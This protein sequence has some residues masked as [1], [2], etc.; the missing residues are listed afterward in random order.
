MIGSVAAWREAAA[1]LPDEGIPDRA[2]FGELY[3]WRQVVTHSLTRGHRA[4]VEAARRAIATTL[5]AMCPGGWWWGFSGGK[6]SS[7]LGAIL[8]MD[9]I[10]VPAVSVKDDL[11][12]PGESEF[13]AGLAARWGIR[14]DILRQSGLAGHLAGTSLVDGSLHSPAA[15]LSRTY[16]YRPLAEHRARQ[17]YGG[18]M[19]GLRQEESRGRRLN[20]ATRGLLYLRADGLWVAQPIARLTTLDVHAVLAAA[21]VPL[22]P[23]Y[24][25]VDPGAEWQRLRKSWWVCAGGPA[26]HGHYA[27][28]R[29]WWPVLWQRAVEID[30]EV[31]ALS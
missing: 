15:S 8:A 29:R 3:P 7:A 16:F 4:R 1:G 30:S 11:D 10:R 12:Y 31:A 22:L 14:C 17:G 13:V 9:G 28:L 26:R 6:D 23:V 27:W 25:C 24:L 20:V 2:D 5:E 19:L 18:A 21:D